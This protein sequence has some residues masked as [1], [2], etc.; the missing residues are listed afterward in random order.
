MR[1]RA[2]LFA[3]AVL[4]GVG[5]G[6]F[7]LAEAATAW[8][9]RTTALQISDGLAAAGQD[10]AAVAT[11]G[12]RVTLTG[13]APDETSRFRALEVAR[14]TV[15]ER[16][17]TDATTLATAALAAPPAFALEL[18]RND[19]EISLIGLVPEAGRDSIQAALRAGGLD[20][21]VTDMLESSS[22][23]APEGW[24]EALGFGLSV[25][26]EVPRAKISIAPRTVGVISVADSEAERAALEARLRGAVPA[27]IRLTLDVS[28]P[29]PVITPFAFD[30]RLADG[31][32]R[33][34]ACSAPTEAAA[35]EIAAAL[36]AAGLA[37]DLPCA[38]GL[39]APSPEWTAAVR[40]GVA[41]VADLGGGRFA[42]RDLAAELSAA[43]GTAPDRL[44]RAAAALAEALPEGFHLA[45]IAP[46]A[47]TSGPGAAPAE[48]HFAAVRRLD[49][50]V[51]LSGTVQ[52]RTSRDAIE[53][54]AAA[55]FGHDR[56]VDETLLDPGLPEGW[57]VRILA[58]VE[59]LS[60]L[61]EGR[62]EV[63]DDALLVEGWGLD[64]NVEARIRA[65]LAAKVGPG[66][67]VDVTYNAEA[68]A[69]AAL[70]ARPRP[71]ICAEQI[72][73]IL[74]S[75]S[76]RFTAGSADIVP[77]SAGIIAAIADVLRGCPGAEFEIAGHTDGQ[78]PDAVNRQLS[79]ERAQ[80]VVAALEAQDLP[81]VTLWARGYG[82]GKPVADNATPEGRARNRRID[83]V[84]GP[85][86]PEP[87]PDPEPQPPTADADIAAAGDA[88]V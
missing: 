24:R 37:G 29:R 80:A 58:A 55:L 23:P 27:G 44:A 53:S 70:A 47:E 69:A 38:A 76:I 60:A 42:L 75:D 5:A 14:A 1:L 26:A 87:E 84:L 64:R 77:E 63:T 65:L 34:D 41:A 13:T 79:L 52:D 72:D 78:G 11:D 62:A 83:F 51:R 45:T 49:G 71:E 30:L 22:D 43:P 67:E 18:L 81:L 8:V 9:E 54:F 2:I 82:A 39:G 85:P 16:R 19:L 33:L 56:V 6:A 31:A 61:E 86:Q 74:E 59:A 4:A 35:G 50:S 7:K 20:D 66:A 15:D 46:P 21:K 68:A 12:L 57:P 3:V 40:A 88:C 25:L 36:R 73:A 32:G 10:W 28:A 48:A 17:I